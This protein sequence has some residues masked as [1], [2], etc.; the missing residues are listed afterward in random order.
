[1][2]QRGALFMPSSAWG[3]SCGVEGCIVYVIVC[4]GTELWGRGVHCLCHH[5]HGD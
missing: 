4:E 2:G 3:L 5:L 1:M